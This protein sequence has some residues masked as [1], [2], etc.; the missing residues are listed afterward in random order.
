MNLWESI[1]T[2][3]SDGMEITLEEGHDDYLEIQIK[4]YDYFSSESVPF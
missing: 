4:C 1:K 3:I 2:A